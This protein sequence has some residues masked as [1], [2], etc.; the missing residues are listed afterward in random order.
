MFGVGG[1]EILVIALVALLLFGTD[2]LPKNMRKFMKAWN[3]FRGVTNDLQKGWL[4]VRDQVT[5]DIL[6]ERSSTQPAEQGQQ[7]EA[8]AE[9]STAAATLSSN[10]ASEALTEGAEGQASHVESLSENTIFDSSER[11]AASAP[12]VRPAQG[13]LAR[14]QLADNHV[15]VAAAVTSPR[16]PD[17]ST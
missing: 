12:Q 3:D 11:E 4:D 15:D 1:G 6:T 2:D 9:D 10:T 7:S 8:P 14:G 17:K 16:D 13:A 5:R